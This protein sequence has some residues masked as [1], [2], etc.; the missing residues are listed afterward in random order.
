MLNV[1]VNKQHSYIIQT[2]SEKLD[3]FLHKVPSQNLLLHSTYIE[4]KQARKK[5]SNLAKSEATIE[6]FDQVFMYFDEIIY[7]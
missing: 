5:C 1:C 4:T 7:K 2:M 6:N 3:T